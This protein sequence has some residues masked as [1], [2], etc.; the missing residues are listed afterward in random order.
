M[1][2]APGLWKRGDC[3]TL[4]EGERI[5]PFEWLSLSALKDAYLY[6]RFIKREIFR[7]LDGLVLRTEL[8]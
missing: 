2:P 4:A 8:Q 6:P 7:L 3:L 5:R 1:E